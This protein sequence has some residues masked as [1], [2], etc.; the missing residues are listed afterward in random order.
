MGARIAEAR[1]RRRSRRAGT[2]L[3]CAAVA[4]LFGVAADARRSPQDAAAVARLLARAGAALEGPVELGAARERD[5][6]ALLRALDGL[7][8][9]VAAA[10]LAPGRLQA[11]LAAAP[12][13]VSTLGFGES[14]SARLR[15]APVTLANIG[16]AHRAQWVHLNGAAH[17]VRGGERFAV[18]GAPDCFAVI[19][20]VDPQRGRVEAALACA[21]RA[22]V[23]GGAGSAEAS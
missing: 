17:A 11:I 12:L 3:L 18:E 14:L 7:A 6:A 20:G 9:T 2:A 4:L 5:V 1:R 19:G 10:D 8:R 22:A 16:A 21:P 13:P 23:G 15:G